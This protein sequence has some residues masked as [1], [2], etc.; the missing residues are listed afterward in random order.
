MQEEDDV[1]TTLCDCLSAL[2]RSKPLDQ[3]LD[4]RLE[5][6]HLDRLGD[7]LVRA[8]GVTAQHVVRLLARRQHDHGDPRGAVVRSHPPRE[9]Q[10]VHVRHV[11][12][13]DDE[14]GGLRA[15]RFQ[16]L[17]AVVRHA[18]LIPVARQPG[19]QQLA[20]LLLVIDEE[21]AFSRH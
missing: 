3:D 16:S 18:D 1:A 7:V 2:R 11:H 17:P 10:T 20:D 12:V 19:R 6:G 9:L 8:L 4:L 21:D 13:G 15:N 14:V 5:H